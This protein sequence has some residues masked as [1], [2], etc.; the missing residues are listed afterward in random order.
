M[1]IEKR[2]LFFTNPQIRGRR[3]WCCTFLYHKKGYIRISVAK[4]PSS[5]AEEMTEDGGCGAVYKQ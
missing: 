4:L 2:Y 3:Q 1:K 5:V